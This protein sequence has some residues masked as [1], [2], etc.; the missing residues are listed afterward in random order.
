MLGDNRALESAKPVRNTEVGGESRLKVYHSPT[1]RL[2]FLFL[3]GLH[4]G[5][6]M[7][8]SLLRSAARA[9]RQPKHHGIRAF[10]TTGSRSAEVELTIG[11]WGCGAR[12]QEY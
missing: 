5:T 11:A 4:I 2:P 10:S 9:A 1:V 7:R 6:T 8:R 3:G 12:K